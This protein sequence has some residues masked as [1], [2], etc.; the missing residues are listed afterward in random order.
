[1][2]WIDDSVKY[3]VS[4][5]KILIWIA[6]QIRTPESRPTGMIPDIYWYYT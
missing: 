5:Y 4:R 6:V 2:T 1:M 3:L